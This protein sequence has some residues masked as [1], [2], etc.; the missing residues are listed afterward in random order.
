MKAFYFI[1][2]LLSINCTVYSQWS[3]NPDE[4]LQVAVQGGNIHVVPN[5]NGGAILT[6]NNFD[7]ELVSTYM[8][9]IDKY[10]YLKWFEPEV[11]A[12]SPGPKNYSQDIFVSD[13]ES[14]LMGYISGYDSLAGLNVYRKYNAYVNKIDSNGSRHWGEYGI[15]VQVDTTGRNLEVDYCYDSDGGIF[16]F[17]IISYDLNYP[18]YYSDSLFIQH[19]SKD[20]VRLWGENGIFI[21]DSIFTGS[22]WWIIDDDS[23][24]IFIQYGALIEKYNG[25]GEL[26]WSIAGDYPEVIKD[27]RGGI[28]ISGVVDSYPTNKLIVNRI[29]SNGEKLWGDGGIIIDDSVD[30]NS[31]YAAEVF[32]NSDSTISVFWDTQWWPIDDLFLQRYTLEGEPLWGENSRLSSLPTGKIKLGLVKS[33]DNSNI[34]VWGENRDP[35]GM[36]VQKINEQGNKLWNEDKYVGSQSLEF[37]IVTDGND[38][39]IICWHK[40]PPWGGIYAQQISKNGN[41]GEIITSVNED[42]YIN[43]F[44]NS[45]S[46]FQNYPNPF[47]PSTIINYAVKDA[48]VVRLKV[49]DILGSEVAELVNSTKEAGYH[50]IEFNAGNLPSGFYI[51]TLQVNGFSASQKMLLLK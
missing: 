14:I 38:G 22:F 4:N 13:D 26:H 33:E 24:G 42:D 48:G 35:V 25:N 45:F 47:N 29:S 7:Y 37:N 34:I 43:D 8:Q 16:A 21:A 10:G 28:I 50:S 19:I 36:Y 12:D 18:P 3:T 31:G 49:Y 23:G 1:I 17:C 27:G 46:L 40:D 15:S 41:L 20:G 39:G 5:G 2:L 51:Y 30:N 44:P 11:I 32:L 9:C 6:F